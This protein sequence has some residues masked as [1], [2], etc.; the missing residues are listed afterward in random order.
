MDVP[1][2]VRT[3]SSARSSRSAALHAVRPYVQREIF[4]RASMYA[5]LVSPRATTL[6]AVGARSSSMVHRLYVHHSTADLLCA[7]LLPAASIAAWLLRTRIGSKGR[8]RR[9]YESHY[10]D[11]HHHRA[12]ERREMRRL[13]VAVLVRT[14]FCQ[15]LMSSASA[16]DETTSYLGSGG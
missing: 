14:I 9:C 4:G 2:R 6:A 3:R 13:V 1:T 11:R 15:H 12:E 10:D 5:S 7:P 16:P 8:T